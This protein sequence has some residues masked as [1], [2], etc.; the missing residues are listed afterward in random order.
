MFT[1]CLLVAKYLYDD[2]LAM[3]FYQKVLGR[4]Y[5]T[6]TTICA[7]LVWW[8]S[9]CLTKIAVFMGIGLVMVE[10]LQ[11]MSII[12]YL[13][14]NLLLYKSAVGKRI[15]ALIMVVCCLVITEL[16]SY[17]PGSMLAGEFALFAVESNFTSIVL[18]IEI[19]I[20]LAGIY[21]LLRLWR[22]MEQIE[23]KTSYQLWVCLL[24]PFSHVCIMF[25]IGLYYTMNMKIVPNLVLL[26][27]LLGFAADIYVFV[28][29]VRLNRKEKN[30][31]ELQK[32]KTQYELEQFRYEE[33][34]KA[35]EEM[36]KMRHDFRN[37]CITMKNM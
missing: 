32:L 28:L 9:Q 20:E 19:P 23:W 7:T 4:K 24:Y 36:R 35:E 2:V 8:L 11:Y 13:L 33:L 5:S 17:I 21:L 1:T 16:F 37:Y 22:R 15:L 31:R 18:L 26:G 29:F 6:K 27:L 12:G 25:H 30:E 34:M 14:Y 3:Y 10:P